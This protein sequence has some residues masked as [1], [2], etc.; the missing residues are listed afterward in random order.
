MKSDTQIKQDVLD[1][2]AWDPEIEATR[3]GVEVKDGAVTL[4][5]SISTYRQKFAAREAA[6]RIAGV[7]AVVDKLQIELPSQH[8]MSDSGLA[9][10]IAHVLNWNVSANG[11]DIKAEVSDGVVTLNGELEHQ[12]E[13]ENILRNIEHV[14]GVANVIDLMTVKPQ[15]SATAVQRDILA[16]LR[17]H[18]VVE[19][20]KITVVTT[21]SVVTLEGCVESIDEMERAERAAWAAPG[22]TNVISNLKVV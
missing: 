7:R 20:E 22:V 11:K 15:I 4:L 10:R 12:Y 13:R 3:V 19:A 1:E 18:A 16:A 8:R 17:R 9:E 21:N 5:G 2:L 14:S 6:K